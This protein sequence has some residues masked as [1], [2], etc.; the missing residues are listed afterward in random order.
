M[1]DF[2]VATTS[3]LLGNVPVLDLIYQEEK[4]QNCEF[5]L[6]YLLKAG[7][8]A[9]VNLSCNKIRLIDFQ[10][11]MSIAIASCEEIGKVMKTTIKK[12]MMQNINAFYFK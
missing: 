7:K 2:L 8:I 10:K 11:L 3:G 4:K 5:V 1:R 6:A 12:E 9:Y